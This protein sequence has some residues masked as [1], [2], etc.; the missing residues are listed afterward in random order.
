MTG[1]PERIRQ[2]HNLATIHRKGDIKSIQKLELSEEK[3][4]ED[5][6]DLLRGLTTNNLDE[7]AYYEKNDKRYFIQIKIFKEHII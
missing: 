5:I 4:I 1:K 6:L 3:K 2:D 7:A